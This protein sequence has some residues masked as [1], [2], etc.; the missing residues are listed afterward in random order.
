MENT[1]ANAPLFRPVRRK[2]DHL[3]T[4]LTCYE[5]KPAY[6]V[7]DDLCTSCRTRVADRLARQAPEHYV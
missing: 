6:V 5:R 2:G 3:K 7:T 1:S 4:C